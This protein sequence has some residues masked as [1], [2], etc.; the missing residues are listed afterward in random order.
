M[1]FLLLAVP[2]AFPVVAAG[3]SSTTFE[4]TSAAFVS[5][6]TQSRR[7][8]ATARCGFAVGA[9]NEDPASVVFSVYRQGDQVGGEFQYAS[10]DHDHHRYPHTILT[11]HAITDVQFHG[12]T[13]KIFGHGYMNDHHVHAEIEAYDGTADGRPSRFKMKT[14]HGTQVHSHLDREIRTGRI[15]VKP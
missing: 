8:T 4:P 5:D 13:V 6:E 15:T 1:K 3:P 10:E 12:R 11:L 9:H 7:Q 2:L 14:F